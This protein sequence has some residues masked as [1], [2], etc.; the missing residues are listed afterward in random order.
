MY[1]RERLTRW[2]FYIFAAFIVASCGGGGDIFSVNG[3][4]TNSVSVQLDT[5]QIASTGETNVT[6]NLKD[7][8][9]NPLSG[10]V[11]L[12]LSGA[13]ALGSKSVNVVGGVGTTTLKGNGA[14]IGST[15]DVQAIFVDAQKNVSK[16][17]P[18][19]FTIIYPA[20]V[21]SNFKLSSPSVCVPG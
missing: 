21:P 3:Q 17:V 20:T 4:S 11:T 8:A 1:N 9:N 14:Q 12:A 13:G 6:V 7:S 2:L 10:N 5:D 16:S 19:S 15:G 18:V